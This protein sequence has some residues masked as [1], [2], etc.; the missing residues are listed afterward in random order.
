MKIASLSPDT[1]EFL[2]QTD[3]LARPHGPLRENPSRHDAHELHSGLPDPAQKKPTEDISRQ[4]L[5]NVT[6]AVGSY[7]SSLGVDLKFIIDDRTE[8]VQVEV[9]DHETDKVIRKIP[10][11]EMLALAASIE[12]M[13][14]LFLN[15]T[16]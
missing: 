5:Q 3:A 4:K 9:R 12:D 16:L 10:A 11:D 2:S 15:K 7:M 1:Q 13:V 14:G 6:E 8:K